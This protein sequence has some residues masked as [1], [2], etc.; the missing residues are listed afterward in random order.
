[1][2]GSRGALNALN[3]F[4]ADVRDGL[5]PFLGVYLQSQ[6]WSPSRIGWVM[7]VGALAGTVA[8]APLGALVD[9][10]EAKR[11]LVVGAAL[12]VVLASL[13]IVFA[14]GFIATAASQ[15]ISG[16]A[17][18]AIAPAIAGITLGMV[19]QIGYAHQTG[20]NEAF[21]HAGNVTAAVLAGGFGYLFGI[22]AVFA[23]MAGMAAASIVA[24]WLIDPKHIDHRAARGLS[25]NNGKDVS[26]WSVL[27]TSKPLLVLAVTLLLFH[28]GNAAMLPLLGQAMVAAGAGDPSAYTGATVVVAQLTMVPMALLAARLAE[29][30]GYWIVFVLA[31][32]ALP[33]RGATAALL[34]GPVGLGPVQVLDGVGAGL[35]GVAVP[36]L[37]ARILAGTGHVN[38]GLGA[39]MAMQGIGAALSPALGGVI[40]ERFGYA[41]SFMALGLVALVALALW[42]AARPWTDQRAGHTQ[43]GGS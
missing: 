38:A 37:V 5:G 27:L 11:A 8:T 10:I 39:V 25:A 24:V 2:S 21:N 20:R 40:A 18:A 28:L 6:G 34:T 17:G 29:T 31:L 30:R 3:F 26:G 19:G 14:P 7:T 12:A 33:V 32:V 22:G 15:T 41:A 36:G 16:M 23:V 4:M 43:A 35:L 9:R 42:I 1:M 13:V